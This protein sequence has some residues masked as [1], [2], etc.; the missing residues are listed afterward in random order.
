[1]GALGQESGFSTHREDGGSVG[2]WTGGQWKQIEAWI[3]TSRPLCGFSW[4]LAGAARLETAR[5][6][7]AGHGRLLKKWL[8][9]RCWR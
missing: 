7:G 1:M 5:T 4:G 3:M 6:E 2:E 8:A 9:W